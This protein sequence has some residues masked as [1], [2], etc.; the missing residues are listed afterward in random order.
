MS[1]T[2]NSSCSTCS[3]ECNDRTAAH[4]EFAAKMN[5]VSNVKKVIGVVSGKGGV[6]KSLITSMLAINMNNR[7]FKTA[8]MDADI[9]G[10]SIPKSFGIDGKAVSNGKS[11]IPRISDNGIKVM[12][13]NLILEN[14]SDPVIWRGPIVAGVVKQ[15]WTDVEWG[16][17]DYMF[18]DMPPGTGDVPLTVFQS[19][20]VDGI[21]V[22]T[23]P[24]ELVSMIVA[25]AAKMARMM[26]VPII[27]LVEN[28]SYL[29]CPDC[30]KK[31]NVFGES[32]VEEVAAEQL[33]QNY[34]RV[35]INPN[36]A[37][38]VDNGAVEHIDVSVLD[39]LAAALL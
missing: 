3:V 4:N 25:K 26:N 27:G 29:E 19:L 36:I 32:R 8:I 23:S 11:L 35:P 38:A 5:E 33:I 39:D 12:S 15:F 16:D 22:V 30:G 9:T 21:I 7:G 17:I 31:I 10:P 2:C 18:V 1:E 34:A 13:V 14:E 24:Q 28:M 20:P 37:A 6:G